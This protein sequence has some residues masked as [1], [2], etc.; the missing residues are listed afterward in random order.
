MRIN[1]A[2]GDDGRGGHLF[3]DIQLD[4][5][6]HD[7]QWD[8]YGLDAPDTAGASGTLATTLG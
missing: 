7:V 6:I 1:G 3:V 8:L 5:R 4:F 2:R